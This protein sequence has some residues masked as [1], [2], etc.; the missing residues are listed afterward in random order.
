MYSMAN[1]CRGD[2]A[3][4]NGDSLP[5]SLGRSG[6]LAPNPRGLC[7]DWQDALRVVLLERE[8]P[9]AQ[10]VLFFRQEVE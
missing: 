7:V 5:T 4:G 10:R 8:K 6:E 1:G 3:I 9:L 2:D